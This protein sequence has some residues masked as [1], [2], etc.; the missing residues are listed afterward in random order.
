MKKRGAV[1]FWLIVLCAL[2]GAGFVFGWVQ[3]RLPTD[4]YGVLVTKTHGVLPQVFRAGQVDWRWEKLIPTNAELL[5]FPQFD[6]S[7]GHTVSGALPSAEVYAAQVTPAPDFTYAFTYDL[8]LGL[9]A[10]GILALVA[11][12]V[13]TED[14]ATGYLQDKAAEIA[15]AAALY[16][17]TNESRDALS[18]LTNALDSAALRAALEGS[19]S[20]D[21]TGVELQSIT[22][23]QVK[24]PD[25]ELYDQL[26]ASYSAYRLQ[27]DDA[28]KEAARNQAA[29]LVR[30][31]AALDRM[32]RIGALFEKYPALAEVFNRTGDLSASLRAFNLTE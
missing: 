16:L 6:L 18:R 21:M 31:N 25:L 3:F 22:L 12:G 14:G 5:T 15:G 30:S 4:R 19:S 2:A 26:K 10:E 28:L 32:E 7:N 20:V 8:R 1:I 11:G 13:R 9:T 27:V 17:V 24:M 23:S 29:S